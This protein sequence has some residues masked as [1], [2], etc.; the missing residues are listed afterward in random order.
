MMA[1]FY[2]SFSYKP[3]KEALHVNLTCMVIKML[4]TQSKLEYIY[5]FSFGG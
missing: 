4:M 5:I 3:R 1:T 2:L